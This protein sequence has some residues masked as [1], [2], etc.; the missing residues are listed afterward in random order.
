M[1]TPAPGYE[2]R[3][4]EITSASS[5]REIPRFARDDIQEIL[6]SFLKRDLI[7]PPDWTLW[8]MRRSS[9]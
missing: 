6:F 4:A 3:V 1:T 7:Y 2:E 9:P 5:K 8:S